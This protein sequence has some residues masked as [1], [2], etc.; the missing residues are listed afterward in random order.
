M[1]SIVAGVRGTESL[2]DVTVSASVSGFA[3]ALIVVEE[4]DTVGSSLGGAGVGQ[5]L[6]DVS[7]TPV[8]GVSGATLAGEAANLVHTRA[9][10][11][12]GA[13]V[14]VIKVLLAIL[15]ISSRRTGAL[16]LAN[17]VETRAPVVTGIASTLVDVPLALGALKS[18][19][20][21][22][23]VGGEQ[24]CAGGAVVTGVGAASVR[25]VLAVGA[26]EPVGAVAGVG[27]PGVAAAAPVPAQAGHGGA[28]AVGRHLAADLPH[29]TNLE[30][31]MR[32][33]RCEM[34]NIKQMLYLA[35]PS[36]VARA[37]EACSVL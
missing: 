32:E 36:T 14:A 6:V 24:V 33:F 11:E 29:V 31:E 35:S 20:A 18:L 13:H 37:E 1:A 28:L 34:L 4:L 27:E 17:E 3:V 7:L 10:I 12:A 21:L 8:P 5:T 16:E 22:T 9:S 30:N 26:P 25:L 2:L 23:A 19:G 15:S